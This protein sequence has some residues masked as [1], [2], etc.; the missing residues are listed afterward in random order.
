MIKPLKQCDPRWGSKKLGNSNV[1]S[2]GCTVT[3]CAMLAG[4]TPDKIVDEA[5]FTS[6]GAIYWQTLKSLKFI[7]RGYTYENTKVLQAIKDYG[8]CLVE[9]SMPQAPGG[10]HW[11]LF[12]GD[13]KM[14]DPLT[15][16]TEST[17]KYTPTGYCILEP[18]QTNNDTMP[19]INDEIIGK[20]S[21]RD[22]VVS[23]Y[24]FEIGTA[25]DDELLLELLN[26]ENKLKD[27]LTATK[28]K[29][30]NLEGKLAILK[31]EKAKLE[32]SLKEANIKRINA[33]N[34]LKDKTKEVEDLIEAITKERK[35]FA[36]IEKKHKE[37]TDELIAHIK[38]LESNQ[39]NESEI[40][41]KF[42]DKVI[43]GL[44]GYSGEKTL[45]GVLNSISQREADRMKIKDELETLRANPI[46]KFIQ[47]IKELIK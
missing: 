29:V 21:Q 15:G 12:I 25:K 37:M 28:N 41:A 3:C 45:E 11:V 42:L 34:E 47:A 33:E 17:S 9:V 4:T 22:K 1:A 46:I 26:I 35:E 18:L 2:I 16:K 23:H 38:K 19:N 14:N 5:Q 6:G 8:G 24:K 32:D 13:G 27:E 44:E 30:T 10:K 43:E 36:A 20:S 7:W 39:I 40:V 31:M